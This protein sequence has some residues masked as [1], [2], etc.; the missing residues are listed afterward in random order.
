MINK[1]NA[2]NKYATHKEYRIHFKAI[3]EGINGIFWI[4]ND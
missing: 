4:F 3:I 2:L 1:L